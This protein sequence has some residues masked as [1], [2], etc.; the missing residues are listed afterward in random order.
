M[1]RSVMFKTFLL[2]AAV[3]LAA[4]AAAGCSSSTTTPVAAS[5]TT[6]TDTYTDTI[7]TASIVSHPFT[8]SATG[9]VTI[10]LTSVAPLTTMSLG[11]ALSTW[12]GTTCGTNFATNTDARSG[13]TALTGTANSGNYCVKVYDSGNVPTDGSAV[14]V[15]LQ[16][17][18]P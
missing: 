14:T 8:V 4:G 2:A 11:V 9:P 17:V 13:S 3:A 18:H 15:G 5:P 7:T 12:D 16:V 1:R 10:S 6:T